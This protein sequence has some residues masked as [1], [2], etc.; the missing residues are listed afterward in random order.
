MNLKKIA[1]KNK[2]MVD[3]WNGKYKVGQKVK[4]KK[5]DGSFVETE[6]KHEATMLGGH[7]AVGWFKDIRGAYSLERAKAI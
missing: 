4:V 5:D 6:T 3:A 7:T 1:I 2:K